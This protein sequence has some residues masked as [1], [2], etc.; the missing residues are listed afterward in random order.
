MGGERFFKNNFQD[1]ILSEKISRTGVDG[2]VRFVK[3][4][5]KKTGSLKKKFPGPKK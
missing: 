4:A 2:I 5:N 3:E 1:Q